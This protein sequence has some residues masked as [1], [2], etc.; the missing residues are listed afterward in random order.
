MDADEGNTI[1]IRVSFTDDAGYAESLTSAATAAVAAQSSSSSRAPTVKGI[2]QVGETLTVDTTGID[3]GPGRSTPAFS[4]QWISNDGTTNTDIPDAT[5]STYTLV[6]EDEGKTIKVEV[7]F[8][9]SQGTKEIRTSPATAAV[10]P[11]ANSP[12]TGAPTITGTAQVG[13]TLTADVTGIADSDGLTNASYS[14]QWVSNDGSSDTDI[15]GAT[16]SSYTLVDANEGDTIKVRVSF[17]DDGGNAESLTSAATAAVAA[18]PVLLTAEFADVPASHDGSSEFTFKVS[19]SEA[20]ASSNDDRPSRDL[21]L[22]ITATGGDVKR[23]YRDDTNQWTD[24]SVRIKPTQDGPITVTLNAPG[25]NDACSDQGV[26]CTPDGR[27]LSQTVSDTV[28]GPAVANTAPTGAPTISGTAQ[29]NETL[30]ASVSGISDADGLVNA[31]F[32]YQWIRGSTDISGAKGST[33]TLTDTD[34]GNTIKVRVSFTDDA[35]NAESLTSEATDPVAAAPLTAE[36]EDVPAS[37]DG[38][39]VFTFKVSFS[40][41]IASSNADRPSRDLRL[42]ITATGGDVKRVYRDD[43]NQWT[44]F[45]VRVKPTQDGPITVTLNAPGANDAC[46]DQGVICTPDGRALSHA[47][48]ETVPYR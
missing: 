30:T 46:S 11:R 31:S 21:R 13:E 42:A 27:V 12:A 39:S 18:A 45:S 6:A 23:V 16:G 8:T 32:A 1:K 24:F 14:Y 33:Y 34:E 7:S 10:V 3:T 36:F 15:A 9:N 29:V 37:H 41:A 20:I 25:A 28:E 19:F 44:D 26:I 17:T 22:A 38:S 5:D 2:A 48:T 47:L 43:T 35:G 4:Y 40:E